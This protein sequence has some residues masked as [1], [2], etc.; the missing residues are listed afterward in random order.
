MQGASQ[1]SARR[2]F[3]VYKYM[4]FHILDVSLEEDP[5]SMAGIV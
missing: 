2:A 4:Q 1:S 5:Y 3:V